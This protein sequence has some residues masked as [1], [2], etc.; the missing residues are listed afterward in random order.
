MDTLIHRRVEQARR[1]ENATV[2]CRLKSGWVVLG[3]GQTLRGYCLLLSD[4]VAEDINKLAEA[5]RQQFLADMIHIGDVLLEVTG[6]AL[7]N[8]QILGNKDRA[9]HA[10][11]HPRYREEPEDKRQKPPMI[12]SLLGT[13]KMPFDLV[14][15]QPLMEA[16]AR[17]LRALEVQTV[18]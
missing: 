4:P 7:I 2:I 17:R 15:D 16:I 13:A 14:R 18:E 3:D 5:E 8:Y 12:Y 1:G 11:I 9:L 10:H 6:A